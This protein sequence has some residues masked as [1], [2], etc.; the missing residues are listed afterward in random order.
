MENYVNAELEI[1]KLAAIDTISSS[2]EIEREE[3]E[4]PID[5]Y[6]SV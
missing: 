6:A 3:N 5:R 1:V 4:L 2:I